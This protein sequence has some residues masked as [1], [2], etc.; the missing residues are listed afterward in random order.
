MLI[1]NKNTPF[2][3]YD[4]SV[5]NKTLESLKKANKFGY[6]LHYAM[7]ANYDDKLLNV[8][9][10]YGHGADCVSGGELKKAL[11]VGFKAKDITLAGVGK[12][13]DEIKLAIDNKI[14]SLNIESLEELEVVR[15]IASE[16]NKEIN[17]CLRINPNID[18]HTYDKITTGLE[19]NKFGI[20]LSEIEKSLQIIKE[21][22]NL[23]FVGIHFH[24]GSQ[25][26]DMNIYKILCKKSVDIVSIIESKGHKVETINLGGGLAINYE[27]PKENIVPDFES[28]FET[29]KNNLKIREDQELHF[30]FG[31]A[32]VAQCG[33]LVTKVLY[34]KNTA[35]KKILVVDAGMTDLIRP[36]L[37]NAYHFIENINCKDEKEKYTIVGPICESTD[38]FAEDREI[39]NSKRGDILVIYSA[40]AYGQTMSSEYNLRE[41]VKTYYIE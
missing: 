1:P 10:N 36:A 11:E 5:L 2:Y 29:I 24:I 28:Y 20:S 38:V 6:K 33:F 37:Y 31:R 39:G 30:E 26:N 32:V 35:D 8:I 3:L 16:N 27:N 22:S 13:D 34:S 12:T 41:K 25:I 18:A 14:G 9:K 4:I 21:N 15:K 40:G 19:D 23:V 7:K 17:V